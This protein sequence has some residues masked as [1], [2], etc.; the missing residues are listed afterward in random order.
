MTEIR[1]EQIEKRFAQ[2]RILDRSDIALQ[3]GQCQLL[4]GVNG[5]GKST[6]LRILAGME[7]PNHALI[8]VGGRQLRWRQARRLLMKQCIYLHQAPYLFEGSV[9]YNLAYPL[10]GERVERQAKVDDGLEW[11]GLTSLADQPVHL[12]SGGERQ[13]V[14]L[15]RAWLRQ[16]SFMLLDEPTSNMDTDCRRRTVDLLSE[17]RQRGVGLLVA[18]HD[19]QHFSAVADRTLRLDAGRLV[20]IETTRVGHPATVTRIEQA[21]RFT[22]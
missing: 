15:A 8:H 16:P 6:L 12:L 3:P 5:A 19:A 11:S 21:R 22:G 20:E 18:T 9:A 7:S 10:R 14:A 13:R 2:R 1:F 4:C 17:L